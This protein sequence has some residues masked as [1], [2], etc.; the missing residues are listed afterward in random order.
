MPEMIA[1]T[2]T[3]IFK[4]GN[5]VESS[6]P[7][8]VEVVG[9]W[10]AAQVAAVPSHIKA[11]YVEWDHSYTAPNSPGEIVWIEF[12]AFGF[13]QL[14]KGAFDCANPSHTELLGDFVWEGPGRLTLRETEYAIQ[15]WTE[16]LKTAA[17][18]NT[19]RGLVRSRNLLLLVAWHDDTVFDVS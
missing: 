14:S 8:A 4:S 3:T 17:A 13:D 9:Y 10:L 12:H 19:V 15:D 18:S 5:S 7:N 2:C 1:R 16:V 11:V 6:A